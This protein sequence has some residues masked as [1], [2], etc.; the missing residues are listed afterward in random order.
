MSLARAI[1]SGMRFD[2]ADLAQ[3]VE[4]GLVGAAVRRAPQAGDA[5]G[6]AGERVGARRAGQ[7]HGRGRRVLLVVGVEDEDPPHRM[8]DDRI[9]LIGL[10]RDAEGH[11][12]EIA[13]VAEAVL[14]IEERLAERIFERHR[15]QRRHLG[16][17]PVRG[18]HP[19]L[20]DR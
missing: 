19:L 2:V 1:Y 18:D 13:G 10:G 8:L 9:D 16:D 20:A 7:A 14:R 5:R 17:Q 12:Q 11:A 4:R 3:H 6:D 15:D